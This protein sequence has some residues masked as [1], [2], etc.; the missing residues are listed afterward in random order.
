LSFLGQQPPRGLERAT[1]KELWAWVIEN[2]RLDR[3]PRV[4]AAPAPPTQPAAQT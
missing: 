3:V 1:V 4:M 2:W